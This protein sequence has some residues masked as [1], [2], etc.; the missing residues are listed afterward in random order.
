MNHNGECAKGYLNQA[1]AILDEYDIALKE[2]H[3]SRSALETLKRGVKDHRFKNSEVKEQKKRIRKD[4]NASKK[5]IKRAKKDYS[6]AM[7]KAK[8]DH[9]IDGI[10]IRTLSKKKKMMK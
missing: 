10:E 6:A 1:K 5:E 2:Y 4:L 3:G 8:I 7:K 9:K